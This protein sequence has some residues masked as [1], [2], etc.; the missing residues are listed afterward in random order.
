M[1]NGWLGSIAAW[2]LYPGLISAAFLG[3]FFGWESRKLV[4]RLQ[5]RQGPPF[6]QPMF[7]FIKLLGKQTIVPDGVNPSLFYLLPIIS[8]LS[9]SFAMALLPAPLSP[10]RSFAGDLILL[11]YLLEM[12][13]IVDILAGFVTRSVYAQ[14]GSTREALL[15][16][17]YSLPFLTSWIA[18]A[19][20]AGS[21]SLEKISEL[22]FGPVHVFAAAALLLAIPAKLKLNP[23]SIPN[24][25]QEIAAGT[26]TEYNGVPLALFELSH[27]LE[28]TALVGLFAILFSGLVV[29]PFL[30]LIFY[31]ALCAAVIG[32]TCLLAAGT[33]RL[34]VQH[35]FRFFWT[36]G[37]LAAAL[38]IA[39]AI[40][41]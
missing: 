19:V 39:A 37:I 4:A 18:L 36:W 40:I 30:R 31:L 11:L 7:D 10:M 22:P 13:A 24:A 1:N 23:F 6:Y 17:S 20:Q 34:K 12:P 29:N 33:A 15:S 32:L 38:S 27:T 35:A 28:I 8:V 14:V 3:W 26:H 2:L 5:G 16:I 25:E 41:W 21:F 9:M